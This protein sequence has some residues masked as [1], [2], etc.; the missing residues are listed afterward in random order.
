MLTISTIYQRCANTHPDTVKFYHYKRLCDEA[1]L[2]RVYDYDEIPGKLYF[3]TEVQLFEI[4]RYG[5]VHFQT[6]S[7][8]K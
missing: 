3:D 2:I 7:L 5:N 1:S 6:E 4:D 8:F